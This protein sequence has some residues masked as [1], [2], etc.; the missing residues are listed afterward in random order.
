MQYHPM[1]PYDFKSEYTTPVLT[2]NVYSNQPFCATAC[3]LVDGALLLNSRAV[4]RS[5]AEYKQGQETK[6]SFR[7]HITS[8]DSHTD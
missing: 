8:P 7:I 2:H 1:P 4:G 6:T 3:C 5:P